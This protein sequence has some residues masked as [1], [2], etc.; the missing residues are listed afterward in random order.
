M[1]Q[2]ASEKHNN[3]MKEAQ[4]NEGASQIIASHLIE[5]D[6]NY[7]QN[8]VSGCDRHLLGLYVV[9]TESGMPLPDIFKDPS[10]IKR[11]VNVYTKCQIHHHQTFI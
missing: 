5:D 2:I 7:S 10:W 11:Y 4:R 3:L 8:V 1:L 6:N 9:A